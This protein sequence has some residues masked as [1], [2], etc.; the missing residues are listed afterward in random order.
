KGAL[1]DVVEVRARIFTDGHDAV[2]AI[3][4]YKPVSSR[5]WKET[6]MEF[7]D[8]DCWRGEFTPTDLGK[9]HFRIIA[10][11]DHFQSWVRG[12]TK[13]DRADQVNGVDLAIGAELVKGAAERA[14][15]RAATALCDHAERLADGDIELKKRLTTAFSKTLADLMVAHPDRTRVT[16]SDLTLQLIVD[17]ERAVFSTWYELF[18]RS[19]PQ[20]PGEHGSFAD[21]EKHLGYVA[22]MGFDVLYLPPIHPIG[23]TSR[24]GPN[25]SLDASPKDP[26]VPWAIGSPEGGHTA[27]HPDLGTIDDFRSLLSSAASL[28]VEL[29]L[30]VALQCSPDHPWV[31]AHPEWFR[32]RPDGTIQ[33][34]ENP[35]K[36]YHDIYPIDFET[37][38][39]DGLWA[40]LKEVFDFWIEE[41]VRIFRVDNPHTKAFPFWEWLI[42]ALR[43]DHPD[44]ILLAEAFT[45]PAVM[46]RL[47]KVG[48]NQSYTY[49]T[50]RN[51]SHELTTYM[52]ELA[53]VKDFFR[54]NF[55]PNT[56]D[57]LPEVLQ[58]GT[59]AAFISRYVLAATLSSSC[60]IYGPAFELME[61]RPLLPGTEEYLNSEKYQIRQWDLDHKDSLA[62]VI[63]QVNRARH[64]HR[65]LQRNS[66]LTFHQ[67]DNEM[68]LGYSKRAGGDVVLTVVNLDPHHSQTGWID[69]DL[70]AIGVEDASP[71]QLHDLLTDRLYLWS[72][73]RN[74]VELDA[75]GIPAHVFSVRKQTRTERDFDYFA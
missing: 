30:D 62:P 24:K 8:D 25:N 49:F 35:P 31:I 60:G 7:V 48:F 16:N 15:G 63:T 54:P 42:A 65:S 71:Y 26:G 34:A 19:W 57:I 73:S 45:R 17:R 55:W 3:L 9:W 22:D 46:H 14:S 52:H 18:P 50:W 69:L 6:G 10:W 51:T 41:G 11:V 44:L 53:E 36:K 39:P 2:S 32:H 21:V 72:G 40:S 5:V 20:T 4:Q 27:I 13:K 64:S 68:I 56:P 47:A 28:G 66:N 37:S 33:Y 67:V 29:A 70:S 23:M 59:K 75:A 12:L 74:F 43:S 38:D 61:H 1:G 58:T